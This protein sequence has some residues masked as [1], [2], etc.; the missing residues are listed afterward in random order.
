MFI[1]LELEIFFR[2]WSRRVYVRLSL[3]TCTVQ[4]CHQYTGWVKCFMPLGGTLCQPLPP[5]RC[6]ILVFGILKC[7]EITS[8]ESSIDKEYIHYKLLRGVKCAGEPIAR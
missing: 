3:Y 2:E 8:D 6:L 4:G 5:K 7:S 1:N